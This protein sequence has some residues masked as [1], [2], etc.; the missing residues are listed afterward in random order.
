MIVLVLLIAHLMACLWHGVGVFQPGTTWLEYYEL[1]HE[2]LTTKYNYSFYWATM[3]MTTVGY[4]DILPQNNIERG[5]AS[6]VMFVSGGVLSFIV[7]NIGTVLSHI[8]STK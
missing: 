2:T 3:T 8:N 7:S 1:D 5:I 6:L 4:G